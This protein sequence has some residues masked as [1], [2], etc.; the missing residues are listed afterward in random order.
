MNRLE[1]AISAAQTCVAMQVRDSRVHY[2]LGVALGG[3]K[4]FREAALELVRARD[5]NPAD[6]RTHK[7]LGDVLANLGRYEEAFAS[8]ERCLRV[9]PDHDAARQRRAELLAHMKASGLRE[10]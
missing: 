2:Y 8:Y 9:D 6:P 5:L 10:R 4:R 3:I 1:E 7:T